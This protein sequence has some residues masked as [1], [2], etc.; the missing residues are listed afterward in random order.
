MQQK[1]SAQLHELQVRVSYLETKI[2]E[3]IGKISS[4]E[5][6]I[7][8]QSQ[9]EPNASHEYLL[10]PSPKESPPTIIELDHI[11]NNN[12]TSFPVIVVPS[13]FQANI[14]WSHTYPNCV[15]CGCDTHSTSVHYHRNLVCIPL[16][17]NRYTPK[18]VTV[19]TKYICKR[20]AQYFIINKEMLK[21]IGMTTEMYLNFMIENEKISLE[22]NHDQ[23]RDFALKVKFINDAPENEVNV[24]IENM[25]NEIASN[26]SEYIVKWKYGHNLHV[27]LQWI[28]AKVM[29]WR[30]TGIEVIDNNINN[31]NDINDINNI[32]RSN[33]LARSG[34]SLIIPNDIENYQDS[35]RDDDVDNPTLIIKPN[36]NEQHMAPEKGNEIPFE[37]L[38]TEEIILDEDPEMIE[39]FKE[40][41]QDIANKKIKKSV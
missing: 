3:A 20:C 16:N 41:E 35:D 9:A 37:K 27:I 10:L 6:I 4:L 7:N 21:N 30:I 22:Q 18:C 38:F 2:N 17:N 1:H 19:Y 25:F 13:I 23:I 40:I 12:E 31:I 14:A 36:A 32:E 39:M 5:D 8:K 33:P 29:T 15:V 24:I 28:P 34:S 26:Y 11:L